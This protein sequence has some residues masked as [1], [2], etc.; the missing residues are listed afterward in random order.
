MDNFEIRIK[1]FTQILPSLISDVNKATESWKPVDTVEDVKKAGAQQ[2]KLIDDLANSGL[3]YFALRNKWDDFAVDV[4]RAFTRVTDALGAMADSLKMNPTDK[5]NGIYG[6]GEFQ[7]QINKCKQALP[8][9]A[10][11]IEDNR[12]DNM[13]Q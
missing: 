2:D 10:F 12:A 5:S 4:P 13:W 11:R 9:P 1:N 8:R 3:D 7:D 6:M